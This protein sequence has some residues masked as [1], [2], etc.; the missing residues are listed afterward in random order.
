MLLAMQAI[1]SV[2]AIRMASTRWR[3][4][5]SKWEIL[6]KRTIAGKTWLIGKLQ[7]DRITFRHFSLASTAPT[8]SLVMTFSGIKLSH[9][10]VPIEGSLVDH[11]F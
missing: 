6:T 7:I 8:P 5:S 1:T 3:R 10:C 4:V 2:Q 9:W 11:T